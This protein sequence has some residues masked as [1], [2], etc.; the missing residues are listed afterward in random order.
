M[1]SPRDG[2]LGE[3]GE[4]EDRMQLDPVWRHARLSVEEV[5]EG[6]A[7]DAGA[8]TESNEPPRPTEN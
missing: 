6:D 1:K 8:W 5:E 7:G 2:E 3:A 4:P